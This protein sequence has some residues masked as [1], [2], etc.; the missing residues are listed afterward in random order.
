M[1]NPK[2]AA[3]VQRLRRRGL[4]APG[5]RLG[6]REALFRDYVME[7]EATDELR[8]FERSGGDGGLHQWRRLAS[9]PLAAIVAFILVTQE[10]LFNNAMAM[11]TAVG[12]GLA[13]MS[14]F[15]PSFRA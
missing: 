8:G 12:G 3:V 15:V 9:L 1:L 5:P 11:V 10:G 13:W 2:Q 4:L 6:F 14:R 7:T